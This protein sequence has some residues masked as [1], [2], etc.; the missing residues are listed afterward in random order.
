MSDDDDDVHVVVSFCTSSA[1]V[2][3]VGDSNICIPYLFYLIV[4]VMSSSS[5]QETAGD[6]PVVYRVE[7]AKC[8]YMED[9]SIIL[10]DYT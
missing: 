10:A 1:L 9:N 5:G 6:H 3:F 4:R 2:V 7:S 8:R